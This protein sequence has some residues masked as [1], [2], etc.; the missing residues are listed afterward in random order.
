M[1]EIKKLKSGKWSTKVYINKQIGQIRICADTKS[2]LK[3]L[4]L[5]TRKQ[6]AFSTS[7]SAINLTIG[8]AMDRYIASKDGVLSP[9]T[10]KAYKV[11]RNN[12]I[13]SIMGI[14]IGKVA[15][16]E[17]QRA[18]NEEA[19]R[20]T[21]HSKKN[22][23]FK[24]ISPKTL[25]NAH[26]LLS[27]VLDMY[28][29]GI[30]LHTT[31]PKKQ[32]ADIYVPDP[33]EIDKIYNLLVNYRGGILVKP[34]LL[35]TQCGLRESEICALYS[36]CVTPQYV[37]VKEAYVY[38]ERECVIKQPKSYAGYCKVPISEKMSEILLEDTPESGWI[39]GMTPYQLSN[40][41]S[42]FRKSHPELNSKM[43]FHALRHYYASTTSAK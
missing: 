32:K 43:T 6:Y 19:K 42:R 8:E 31:L 14:R 24:T 40:S 23:A 10:I 34:F 26:G 12:Y 28:R 36:D 21:H 22:G 38:A 2:E 7:A 17:I 25:R 39:C 27:A 20:V 9:T 29:P 15:Q 16:E 3:M 11:I 4:E 18:F 35:A 30:T 13:Q 33:Q 1:A 5:E 37:T 41:W